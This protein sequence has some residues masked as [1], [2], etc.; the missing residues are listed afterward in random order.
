MDGDGVSG[1]ALIDLA[2]VF[3]PLI[4]VLFERIKVRL[5]LLSEKGQAAFADKQ[6]GRGAV[7]YD[8]QFK[9]RFLIKRIAKHPDGLTAMEV[10]PGENVKTQGPV[11]FK[12]AP[13]SSI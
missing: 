2:N 3:E 8:I 12:S 7:I 1:F 9:I 6:F 10:T 13:Y 5:F 4:D 11:N